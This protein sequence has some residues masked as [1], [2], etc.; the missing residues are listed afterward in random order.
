MPKFILIVD[1]DPGVLSLLRISFEDADF[2]VETAANG[3]EALEKA[4]AKH[5]DLILLD[6][7]LPEMDGFTVCDLLKKD[8]NTRRIPILA[9]TGLCSEIARLTLLES[10]ADGCITKPFQLE[11]VLAQVNDLL[12][13]SNPAYKQASGQPGAQL[14]GRRL[15]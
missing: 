4:H 1:D 10:G 14:R 15:A 6:L 12:E 3:L 13:R 11:Y 5:P 9:L 2:T 7:M 8:R